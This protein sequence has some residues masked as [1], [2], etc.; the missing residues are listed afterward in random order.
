MQICRNKNL[1][2][3]VKISEKIV[4]FESKI[5]SFRSDVADV[6]RLVALTLT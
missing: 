2:L 5:A 6:S 4:N 1:L 3:S